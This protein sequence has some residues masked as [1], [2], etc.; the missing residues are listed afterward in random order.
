MH[1]ICSHL[2]PW[3]SV[4]EKNYKGGVPRVGRGGGETY[5]AHQEAISFLFPDLGIYWNLLW[6]VH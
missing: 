1:L 2:Y 6:V 3:Q 4:T 5:I